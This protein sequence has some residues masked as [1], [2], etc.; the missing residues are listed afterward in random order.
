MVYSFESQ[1]NAA[2]KTQRVNSNVENNLKYPS[3]YL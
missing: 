3:A 2:S 1:C